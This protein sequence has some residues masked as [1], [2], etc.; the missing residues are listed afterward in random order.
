MDLIGISIQQQVLTWDEF[1]ELG[2]NH[3]ERLHIYYVGWGPDYFETFN[4]IDPLVNPA[5]SSNFAR[6]DNVEINALLA[7]TAA[8]TNTAQRYLYYER[9]QY[10][11][12]DKYAY[13]M[14]LEYDKLY[15]VHAESMKGFPYNSMRNLYMYPCYRE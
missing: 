7:I 3:P 6:I 13:H 15:F 10:L 14:P 9:L 5:S 12:I 4:M 11:I 8:E 2:E 1:I